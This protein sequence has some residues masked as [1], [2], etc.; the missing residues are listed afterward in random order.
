MSVAEAS[1]PS[2]NSITYQYNTLGTVRAPVSSDVEILLDSKLVPQS[3]ATPEH[4]ATLG[5]AVKEARAAGFTLSFRPVAELGIEAMN[6][7]TGV[8]R[9]I[10]A[11]GTYAIV[12]QLPE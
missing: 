10:T 4:L 12:A 1:S 9:P 8:W 7:M 5:G 2:S 11:S 3:H 6:E